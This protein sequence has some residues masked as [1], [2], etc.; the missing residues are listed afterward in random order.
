MYDRAGKQARVAVH[1]AESLG[2]T[3]TNAQSLTD[4][5]VVDL[6]RHMN[7]ILEINP[8][9]GWAQVEAGVVKDQLN[10]ALEPHGY[11]FGYV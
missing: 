10:A 5:I 9:E 6:S 1:R 8:D 2:G 11:F 7:C 4:G 3:G